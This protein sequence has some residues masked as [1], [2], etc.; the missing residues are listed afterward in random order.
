M[1]RENNSNA[2]FAKQC[3][4]E[5]L[6]NLME[7]KDYQKISL[8]EICE[9]AGFSRMAYYRNFKSK[10]DILITYMKM[11]ADQFRAD[12]MR[13]M[14]QSS[15]KSFEILEY[16]FCY[17][18]NY[19]RFVQCLMSANLASVL[20]FGLNYY[21]DTYVAGEGADMKKRYSLYLYSG[22]IFNIFTIWI[23]NGMKESPA[24]M[25]QILYRRM[26]KL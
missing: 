1:N 15:S 2:L 20:Q 11:L 5:A 18:Q 7:E 23:A 19:Q 21:I 17:F 8:T 4:A 25:A 3:I 13:K 14:P 9:T 26:N 10:D 22:G 24:E 12:V 6:I 16:A